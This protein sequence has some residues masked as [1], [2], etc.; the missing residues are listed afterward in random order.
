MSGRFHE[1]TRDS[2]SD[3]GQN[4]T[5]K[6]H[7]VVLGGGLNYSSDCNL[8]THKISFA[9]RDMKEWVLTTRHIICINLFRPSLSPRRLC[10]MAPTASPA[11]Y[12]A[13]IAPVAASL[14]FPMSIG[15]VRTR[16]TMPD[17]DSVLTILKA[18]MGDTGGDDTSVITVGR[19]SDLQMRGKHVV[20]PKRKE[21]G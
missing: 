18:F 17:L 21:P 2:H 19:V 20:Y 3:T 16:P 4:T 8:T 1:V 6:E 13:T 7:R 9:E 11:M 10:I 14:G 15:Y 5:D 12:V